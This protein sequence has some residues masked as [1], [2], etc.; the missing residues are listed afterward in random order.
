MCSYGIIVE[1]KK[2]YVMLLK[3]REVSGEDYQFDSVNY[4]C[5]V[6]TYVLENGLINFE[7]EKIAV[8]DFMKRFDF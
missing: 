8:V 4:G 6:K 7:G 5:G 2:D 1:N 3:Q